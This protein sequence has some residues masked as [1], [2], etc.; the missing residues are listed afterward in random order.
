METSATPW[1]PIYTLRELGAALVRQSRLLTVSFTLLSLAVVIAVLLTPKVYQSELKVLVKRDRADSLVSA[2]PGGDGVFRSEVSEPELL[3]EVE[4]MQGHDLLEQVALDT[5][6]PERTPSA[7]KARDATEALALTVNA[8]RSDL[9]VAPIK[10]TWMIGITYVSPDPQLAKKVLDSFAR[11]YLVKHLAVRRPPGAYDFFS[12]QSAQSA[13][14]LRMAKANLQEFGKH[15]GIVSAS[16]QKDTV[17]QKLAEFEAAEQ[18]AQNALAETA[19]RVVALESE[20][21]RT[22]GRQTSTQRSGD[23]FGLIQEMQTRML[24]LELKRTEL[25]QKFTPQ[26]RLVVEI[27]QQLEQ[28]RTALSQ[29]RS[30]PVKDET[31]EVNPTMQWVENEIARGR[32]EHAALIA[33]VKSLQATV[34]DYRAR[35]QSLNAED[36]EQQTLLSAVKSA[37]EKY[38]LYE[39]KQEEARISDELD[40][41]RIANVAIAQA[42]TLP[43]QPRRTRSLML[44]PL[45]LIAALAVSVALALA[46]DSLSSAVR[47]PEELRSLLDVP[48]F[49]VPPAQG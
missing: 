47:T 45:G 16:A 26:Y 20:R 42:P 14:E 23:S 27:D 11:L 6:L 1:Q 39:R 13:E 38:L 25:L 17:L 15:H 22:P 12:E 34:K 8:L 40:H 41:T 28:V 19:Q 44:L 31:T 3:S 36:G 2:T 33:R 7:A 5:H 49:S 10:K 46:K 37:E 9:D 21:V 29:A 30:A 24:N 4:L 35:A 32:S 43:F 18:Q 48:V